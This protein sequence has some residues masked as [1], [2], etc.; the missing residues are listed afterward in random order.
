MIAIM[1][2]GGFDIMNKKLQPAPCCGKAPLVDTR[3]NPELSQDEYAVMC[4][5]CGE[6]GAWATT[7][8][9]AIRKWGTNDN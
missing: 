2:H 7:K 6:Q 9:Q 5:K 8:E 4:I 1:N 3:Y